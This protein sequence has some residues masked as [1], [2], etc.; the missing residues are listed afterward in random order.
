MDKAWKYKIESGKT[1]VILT[2]LMSGLFCLLTLWLYKTN[3]KGVIFAEIF[4]TLMVLV[5]ILAIYR[6]LFYKVLIF[7][8]GF[9]YQTSINNGKYYT[10]DDIE[11]AWINSGRSQNGG[12]GEYCNI[13]LYNKKMIRFQF[14]YN[15]KKGVA[16]LIKRANT[17]TQ[18]IKTNTLK[19]KE[20]YLIDGK[21]FGKTRITFG[22][23]VLAVVAFID[24]FFIKEIGFNMIIIP[25]IVI[26]IIIA[27]FLFDYY[28]FFQVKIEKNSFYYQTT[29]FNGRYYKYS[30]IADCRKIKRVVRHRS[31]GNGSLHRNYYFYFEFTDNKGKKHKF[32][33]EQQ[34]HEYEVNIL[35]DRIEAAKS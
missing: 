22:M 16:Y 3:N 7:D 2:F 25:S 13:A 21:V 23:I 19:E 15:D 27:L 29:P 24:A 20:D 8:E 17:K 33:Y 11:K 4:T 18:S 32:Q 34:I 10:Y 14:F 35:K 30:E 28:L 9:Y 1:P 6:L 12:Q 31:Y 26:I 5:F